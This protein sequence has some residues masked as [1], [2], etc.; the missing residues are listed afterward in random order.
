MALQRVD[1]LE[2]ARREKLLVSFTRPFE[3]GS[4]RGYVLDIGPRFF[5]LALVDAG[6]WFNGY[7]CFR[8]ADVREPEVPEKHAAFTEAALKKRGE[9]LPR[10]PSVN[11]ASVEELLFSA[12][13]K[14]PL[15]TIH[16][17]QND[18]D[19]CHIGRALDVRKGR[20]SLLEID[21]DAQW[22]QQPSEYRVAEITRIDFGG[23]YEGALDLVGGPCPAPT[24]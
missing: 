24:V 10:K 21:P 8:V 18:P 17:E 14:F 20:L 16:R 4:V 1:Q 9:R 12:Q 19:V 7:S 22:E 11:L 23:D 3:D 5:L 13:R 6:I 2:R 15:V